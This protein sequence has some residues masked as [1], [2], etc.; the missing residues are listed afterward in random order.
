MKSAFNSGLLKIETTL[1]YSAYGKWKIDLFLN[2]IRF[3]FGDWWPRTTIPFSLKT[4]WSRRV[5]KRR[6]LR[7]E[8]LCLAQDWITMAVKTNNTRS[9]KPFRCKLV[10]MCREF[11]WARCNPRCLYILR[12]WTVKAF[13]NFQSHR[14]INGLCLISFPCERNKWITNNTATCISKE[15][16][17]V[18]LIALYSGYQLHATFSTKTCRQNLS[19]GGRQSSPPP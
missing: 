10:R 1:Q 11:E 12:S 6:V 15:I 16:Y 19:F 18:D 13:D 2:K 7:S 4:A 17:S 5:R 14:S 8:P 9:R 3:K